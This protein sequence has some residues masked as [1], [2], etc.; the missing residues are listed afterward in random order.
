[1]TRTQFILYISIPL[2][3]SELFFGEIKQSA[4]EY[5][6]SKQI[7]RYK[8][9]PSVGIQKFSIILLQGTENLGTWSAR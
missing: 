2:Y 5:S 9:K 3:F 7:H 1:M 6:P 8:N 4:E